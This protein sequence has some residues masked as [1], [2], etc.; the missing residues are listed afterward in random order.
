M[1]S[2]RNGRTSSAIS[3]DMAVEFIPLYSIISQTCWVC[4]RPSLIAP[5]SRVHRTERLA[6]LE[7]RRVAVTVLHSV[8]H[9][10]VIDQRSLVGDEHIP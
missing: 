6:V 4:A 1:C 3:F 5:D 9:V 7:R 2:S 8:P 10:F